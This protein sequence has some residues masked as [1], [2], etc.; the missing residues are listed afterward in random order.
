MEAIWPD[1]KEILPFGLLTDENIE[2]WVNDKTLRIASYDPSRLL[3]TG[4]SPKFA[5]ELKVFFRQKWHNF[6]FSENRNRITLEPGMTVKLK[7][8]EDITLPKHLYCRLRAND[9]SR[10]EF[11]S[12]A[13]IKT[14]SGF[15][16][17]IGAT[18]HNKGNTSVD[19]RLDDQLIELEFYLKKPSSLIRPTVNGK[20]DLPLYYSAIDQNLMEL[21]KSEPKLQEK[22]WGWL[23]KIF[24]KYFV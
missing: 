24:K 1:S 8:V 6:H 20:I 11:S 23:I 22:N 21:A 13:N 15:S 4:Y 3:D 5:D 14:Q 10:L 17:K 2:N 18:V 7:C 12:M 19:I 9:A 16:G